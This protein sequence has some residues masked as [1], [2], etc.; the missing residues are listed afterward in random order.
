M[1]NFIAELNGHISTLNSKSMTN[2][3]VEEEEESPEN[4]T[5]T[6][7]TQEEEI[8]KEIKEYINDKIGESVGRYNSAISYLSSESPFFHRTEPR[9]KTFNEMYIDMEPLVDDLA[10]YAG[11]YKEISKTAYSTDIETNATFYVYEFV[12]ADLLDVAVYNTSETSFWNGM[13]TT[14]EKQIIDELF[15]PVDGEI[16]DFSTNSISN[17]SNISNIV[18]EN[19]QYF[20]RMKSF[21]SLDKTAK[22]IIASDPLGQPLYDSRTLT[23]KAVIDE[24][25]LNES[26]MTDEEF[27]AYMKQKREDL[28]IER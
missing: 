26:T 21:L 1:R 12:E 27:S 5:P 17:G 6:P 8:E 2:I 23:S 14:T 25:L 28:K 9:N 22:Y 10:I 20:A 7:M 15:V 11:N 24:I 3:P 19:S 13:N 16:S 4:P 18:S